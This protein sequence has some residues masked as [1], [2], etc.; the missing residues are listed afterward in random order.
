VNTPYSFHP[1]A[2][3]D[4]NDYSDESIEAIF[5]TSAFSRLNKRSIK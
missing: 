2:I 1:I 5:T 3:P 4:D